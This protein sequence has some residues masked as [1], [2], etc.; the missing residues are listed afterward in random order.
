MEIY[1]VGTLKCPLEK[2]TGHSGTTRASG[3]PDLRAGELSSACQ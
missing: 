2:V 1:K 3:Q